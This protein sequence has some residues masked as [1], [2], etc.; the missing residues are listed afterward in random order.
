MDSPGDRR[1]IGRLRAHAIQPFVRPTDSVLEYGA[2]D[3]LNLAELI[4]GRKLSVFI[5]GDL[6]SFRDIDVAL[7]HH[8]LE[9]LEEPIEIVRK[10]KDVLKPGGILLVFVLY[11]KGFRRPN[12]TEPA[13]HFYSWNVQTLGNL[14]IDCGY[15]FLSGEVK[16]CPNEEAFLRWLPKIGYS[17]AKLGSEILSPE[18]EVRVAAKRP[19]S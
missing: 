11:D 17:L 7:C 4:A 15:E 6:A 2:R 13:K 10:L 12:L 1:S 9:Y 16:R 5:N 3:D 14:L 18:F 8:V 19:L